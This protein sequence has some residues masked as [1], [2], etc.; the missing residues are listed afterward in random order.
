MQKGY[1]SIT[2]NLSTLEE[3]IAIHSQNRQRLVNYL[4]V[5]V[6]DRCNLRCFYCA[7]GREPIYP[8][9]T[10][11]LI[12]EE[13]VR[14]VRA[15][16][17][18]GITKIR[19]T[20]GEP[21]MRRGIAGLIRRISDI[22]RI[23][24]VGLTTNGVFLEE[25]AESLYAA[26]LRH[27]NVSLDTLNSAKYRRITGGDH[28][29]AVWRGITRAHA[30]G[31]DPI[32]INVVVVR[33]INDDELTDF[34]RLAI[35][36]PYSV[37]FIEYMPIGNRSL[38]GP[39][40]F[41]PVEE[42]HR[43]LAG[44]GPLIPIINSQLDGPALRFRWAGGRG[45]LGFIGAIS[46]RFCRN[47]NRLR[48][49]SEGKLRPCLAADNEIDL[50]PALAGSGGERQLGELIRHAINQKPL[51]HHMTATDAGT[52]GRRRMSHIGG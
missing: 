20:G 35:A 21:L 9:R 51:K 36:E 45:E 30:A 37:R 31:F 38:W 11:I 50:R 14:V 25:M 4:R 48:L 27:I 33:G 26:G 42:I 39:D 7:P 29:D 32:K 44:L 34:G 49:T 43:R 1:R 2:R 15:A 16:G 17:Q 6:T 8:K 41:V 18:Q 52:G 40:R 47:C 19:L 10:P 3:K 46:H 13:I 5:S 23:K 28:F 24:A 12:F 22:D